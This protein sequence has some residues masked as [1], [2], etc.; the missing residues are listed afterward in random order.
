MR[1]NN[2]HWRSFEKRR[3]R[4]GDVRRGPGYANAIRYK[5]SRTLFIHNIP[6]D[7]SARDLRVAFERFGIVIGVYLPRKYRS[8][9]LPGFAYVEYLEAQDAS[10][11][12]SHM[13]GQIFRE[14]HITVVHATSFRKCLAEMGSSAKTRYGGYQ[15]RHG[16]QSRYCSHLRSRSPGYQD[17]Q[18][19]S[20][21]PAPRCRENYSVSPCYSRSSDKRNLESTVHVVRSPHHADRLAPCGS[22]SRSTDLSPACK[23]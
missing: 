18:S 15:S 20:C 23:E 17:R 7:T 4:V 11:A 1:R 10:D 13:N 8:G 21:S 5:D 19:R 14:H 2:R 12:Q 6:M 16:S 9:K 3:D 22:H